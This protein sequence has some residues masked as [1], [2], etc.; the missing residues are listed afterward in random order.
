M[1]GNLEN[2]LLLFQ[3]ISFVQNEILYKRCL[4]SYNKKDKELACH[5][6]WEKKHSDLYLLSSMSQHWVIG[7]PYLTSWRLARLWSGY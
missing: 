3:N 7:S 6:K 2:F 4:E 5:F 1:G